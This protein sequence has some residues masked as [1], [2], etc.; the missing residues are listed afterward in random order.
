MIRKGLRFFYIQYILAKYGIDNIVLSTPWFSG[1]KFIAC[2]NPWYW[3]GR[4]KL[5]PQVRLRLALEALGPIFIKFGQAL[6]TRRD[7]LP[8]SYADEL[9][10]LQD[11]VPP[12][13]QA[14]AKKILR[15]A[16]G[17][18]VNHYFFQYR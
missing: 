18:R 1:F 11:R 14:Q 8:S 15:A 6:S 5:K 2:L 3:S 9:A 17:R 12:F 4:K 10:L 13:S 7:L 16:Y